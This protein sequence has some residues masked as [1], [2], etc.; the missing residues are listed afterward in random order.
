M[1]RNINTLAPRPCPAHP[2]RRWLAVLGLAAFAQAGQPS[3]SS[4]AWTCPAP[5]GTALRSASLA[6]CRVRRPANNPIASAL[7]LA[8]NL[9]LGQ[10]CGHHNGVSASAKSC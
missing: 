10:Q 8:L 4:Q 3:P 2:V 7:A 1:R 9:R 5:L 6:A